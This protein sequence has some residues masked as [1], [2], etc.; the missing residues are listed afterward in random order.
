MSAT[1]TLD[2]FDHLRDRVVAAARAALGDDGAD[3]DAALHRSQHADYQ[4][5]L[6]MALAR[7]LKRNPRE[8]AAA[9][10]AKLP[11]DDVIAGVEVSGPGFLNIALR[12]DYLGALVDR[13]RA[14]ADGRLGVPPVARG[15]TVVIDY[16]AP[17]VAKEM[18]VGHL[19]ST[20]I[21]DSIA[22]LLEWQGHTVVRRN[23]VGDWG[24]PFGMLIE[25]L[26]DVSAAGGEASVRELA[27]FYR[28]ARAK[29]DGD[30]AFADRAR[31]RV[32]LLQ[33]GDAETL[34]HWRRL[35][36][37]SVEHFSQ[38]YAALGVT[39]KPADVVGESAYNALLPGVVDELAKKGLAVESEGAMCV[40]PPGFL[41]REGEP[42]PLIV[43]KKEGG[44]GYATT[45]LAALRQR[46]GE[47]GA[48]RLI[49][50][51][52]SPQ[53]QHLAMVFAAARLAGWANDGT[54]LEHVAF[55]S[56]LGP[57]KKMLKT[58]AGES[59]SLAELVSEAV[60]RAAQAVAEKSPELPP[61]EQARIAAA[62]GVGAIKYADLSSD[63]I[64]DYVFDWKRMLAFDGNTAPYL[65][66]AHARIRSIL[67]KAT[68]EAGAGPGAIAV[69]APQ[70]R[71]L[72]LALVQLPGTLERAAETLQPHRICA[73]LYDVA[74]A[75]TAFYESCPVLKAEGATRASR[76]ALCEAAARTLALGLDLLGIAAPEQ[77]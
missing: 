8:V 62:V 24:T 34:G 42:V 16:S 30:A 56:V 19:R 14:D 6:A 31:R 33:S 12:A 55:G 37:V 76:L 38:L 41:G 7:K 69:E 53:A 49:Y 43:R 59:V 67:R 60:A 74:T 73:F 18:H 47:L 61:A 68:T 22:R 5:D 13:M 77:M 70:E 64:K 1:S 3:A 29:F 36:D 4:A 50:V 26:L 45:D 65:M 48:T 35:I 32:V 9:I 52:G 27:A 11:A 71:A 51:V 40:F 39:L 15:E 54:R 66:Y 46:V 72:A 44:Y 75:F 2:P 20:I 57:D 23:H 25:H 10:A 63:R 58:R 21:G 17:N 28:A